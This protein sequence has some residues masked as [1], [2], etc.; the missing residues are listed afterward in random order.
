[1]AQ[2]SA[3]FLSLVGVR[4]ISTAPMNQN[5]HSTRG[6]TKEALATEVLYAIGWTVGWPGASRY[7]RSRKGGSG[8]RIGA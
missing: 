1:M 4:P 2:P 7:L 5:P 6:L 3:Q 8:E